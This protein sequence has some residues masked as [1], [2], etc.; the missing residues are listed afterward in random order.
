MQLSIGLDMGPVLCG[1]L[2]LVRAEPSVRQHNQNLPY[3]HSH[4]VCLDLLSLAYTVQW[5]S[6][7][8]YMA[9]QTSCLAQIPLCQAYHVIG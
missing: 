5:I 2:L 4:I 3:R 9:D 6:S 7:Q 8:Q 1:V